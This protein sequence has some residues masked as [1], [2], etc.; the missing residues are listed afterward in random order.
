MESDVNDIKIDVGTGFV[1]WPDVAAGPD[2]VTFTIFC[3]NDL[4]S[5]NETVRLTV[6]P[7]YHVTSLKL[8]PRGPFAVPVPVTLSGRVELHTESNISDSLPVHI[9]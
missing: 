6:L 8:D 2:D 7:G 4:G 3:H 1:T 5:D 9:R